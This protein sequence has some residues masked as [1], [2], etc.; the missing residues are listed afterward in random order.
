MVS[1]DRQPVAIRVAKEIGCEEVV[2]E[3]LPQNKVEF[4]RATGHR[5]DAE[6]YGWSFVFAGALPDDF[7]PTR[8]VADAPWWRQVHG[9][10][11]AHPEGPRS[12]VAER[13]AHP[14]VHVSRRDGGL[15][16]LV[17][18]PAPQ[19]GGVGVRCT[20]WPRWAAVP[21]GRRPGAGW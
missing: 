3:C 6:V 17:R 5:T 9:A 8:G 14:V 1:G 19:R 11:W 16:R 4:V 15:R 10:D 2:A 7:P 20:R 18:C 21:V 12:D 13:V